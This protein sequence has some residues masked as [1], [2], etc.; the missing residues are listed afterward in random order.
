MQGYHQVPVRAED[1]PKTTIITQFSLFRFLHM[2]FGLRGAA[3]TFQRLTNW[4]LRGLSFVFVYL[5]NILVAN[6]LEEQHT[7]VRFLGAWQHMA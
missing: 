1:V 2:P 7:C 4:V 3:Q 5:D 6:S